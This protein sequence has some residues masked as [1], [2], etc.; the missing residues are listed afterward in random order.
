MKDIRIFLASRFLEFQTLRN[1]I[2]RISDRDEDFMLINLDDGLPSGDS[3]RD[4]SI[5]EISN[6]DIAIFIFGYTYSENGPRSSRTSVTEQEF[7]TAI[8]SRNSGMNV[9]IRAWCLDDESKYSQ[10]ALDF[11]NKAREEIVIGTISSDDWELAAN[12]ILSDAQ[13]QVNYSLDGDVVQSFGELIERELAR[14][15]INPIPYPPSN[16]GVIDQMLQSRAL[17][18]DALRAGRID[19]AIDF[20]EKAHAQVGFDLVTNISMSILMERTDVPSKIRRAVECLHLLEKNQYYGID[21]QNQVETER[22]IQVLAASMR[23]R[24][25]RTLSSKIGKNDALKIIEDLEMLRKFDETSRTLLMEIVVHAGIAENYDLALARFRELWHMYPSWALSVLYSNDFQPVSRKIEIAICSEYSHRL[26]LV[27]ITVPK[28][29]NLRELRNFAIRYLSSEI[30][31]LR[32]NFEKTAD[33]AIQISSDKSLSSASRD[34]LESKESAQRT[35][36]LLDENIKW[37]E[38]EGRE[39]V[40]AAKV[41]G[42]EPDSSS[43]TDELS[44]I[45]SRSGVTSADLIHGSGVIDMNDLIEGDVVRLARDR[46]ERVIT[47]EARISNLDV[48]IGEHSDYLN[49]AAGRIKIPTEKIE[50]YLNSNLKIN[51]LRRKYG[52]D[53]SLNDWLR[54][55]RVGI[56]FVIVVFLV[57]LINSVSVINDAG[58][59][60]DIDGVLTS[61]ILRSLPMFI[62]IGFAYFI[63][64]KSFNGANPAVMLQRIRMFYLVK[65][66]QNFEEFYLDSVRIEQNFRSQ[67]FLLKSRS[68]VKDDLNKILSDV[69]SLRKLIHAAI[70]FQVLNRLNLAMISRSLLENQIDLLTKFNG[71]LP[72]EYVKRCLSVSDSFG[73]SPA[74]AC[75]AYVPEA[76]AKIGD[77]TRDGE[78]N[79]VLKISDDEDWKRLSIFAL[80]LHGR[81]AF[82]SV[83]LD[84]V[85][86]IESLWFRN[87][88]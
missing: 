54:T 60:G 65:Q 16:S 5:K 33:A 2:Q 7:E 3:P 40:K 24:L 56:V 69:A 34:V 27:G 22:R 29:L 32:E 82:S 19:D 6:S 73:N 76:R 13:T 15:G 68:E 63:F 74:I 78:K 41:L 81:S 48:K 23:S 12:S 51:K 84:R 77:I 44:S 36:S 52:L 62:A 11:L 18:M 49:D 1:E 26:Q 61:T 79:L 88:L 37:A 87:Q 70:A 83:D 58:G 66:L 42:V 85:T 80:G 4:R 67:E 50:H 21:V 64:M 14:L 45:A 38:Y 72:A 43:L 31:W 53:L 9:K 8:R 86:E 35:L 47:L 46:F 57:M 28:I 39:I 10:D 55:A 75:P 17:A 25:N 71:W 59:V 20:F 30:A